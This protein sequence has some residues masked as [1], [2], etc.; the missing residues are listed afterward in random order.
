MPAVLAVCD[1]CGTAYP[2]GIAIENS[3]NIRIEDVTSGPCPVCGSMGTVPDGRYDATKNSIYIMATS[4]KSVESLR[5][6]EAALRGV[7][8]PG[9]SGRAVADAIKSQAPEFS[10]LAPVVQRGGFDFKWWLPTVLLAITVMIMMWDR[11]DPASK[12]ASPEQI[13]EI[14]QQVLQ[15]TQQTAPRTTPTP[16]LTPVPLMSPQASPSRN[17]RCP[18]GSG[19]RYRYCHGRKPTG[20]G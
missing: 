1:T 17:A 10:A 7:N 12:G 20:G 13:R 9:V 6:L 2:S 8:R 19:K 4:A 3:G 18:C 5:R 15:Q 14:Y 11:I 16:K